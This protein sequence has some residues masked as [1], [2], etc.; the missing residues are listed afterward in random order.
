MQQ[1]FKLQRIIF[2]LATIAIFIVCAGFV[3]NSQSDFKLVDILGKEHPAA[4]QYRKYLEKYN[5]ENKVFILIESKDNSP[6]ELASIDA[7]ITNVLLNT[8]GLEKVRSLSTTEYF[9]PTKDRLLLSPF[10]KNNQIDTKAFEHLTQNDFWKDLFTNS[11]REFL[12]IETHLR[13]KSPSEITI[14]KLLEYKNSFEMQN[15]GLRMHLL[16][17]KLA[18]FYFNEELKNQQTKM[19]P[20][21]IIVIIALLFYFF[22]S[23]KLILIAGFFLAL[24]FACSILIIFSFEKGLNPYTNFSLL[25]IFVIGTADIVHLFQ[26]VINSEKT[27]TPEKVSH[28]LRRITKPCFLTSFTTAIAFLSLLASD[29]SIIQKFGVYSC[30]GVILC[31]ILTIIVLPKF[32]VWF[33]INFKTFQANDLFS[34]NENKYYNFIKKYSTLISLSSLLLIILSITS[35]FYIKFDD[36]LYNKFTPKHPLSLAVQSFQKHLGFT[37]TIDLIIKKGSSDDFKTRTY[38]KMANNFT[39]EILSIPNVTRVQGLSNFLRY[40]RL[41]LGSPMT[42]NK[43][44]ND[45][46]HLKNTFGLFKKSGVLRDHYSSLLNEVKITVYVRSLYSS[47]LAQTIKQINKTMLK[48][49]LNY[50]ISGFAPVRTAMLDVITFGFV[51]SFAGTLLFIFIVMIIVFRSFSWGMITMIPNLM[52]IGVVFITLSISGIQAEDFIILSVCV[53]L[54]L[55][56]DDTLHFFISF[57]R[58]KETEANLEQNL[59]KTFKETHKA[60]I[61]TTLIFVAVTPCYFISSIALFGKMAI[62]ML[63]AMLMALIADF[64]VIPAALIYFNKENKK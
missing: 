39:A 37:G 36:S 6:L 2:S 54:G 61:I 10:I 55:S 63:A 46:I 9:S 40:M 41:E 3:S 20:L 62:V 22:R 52:P 59:K 64:L 12:V 32:L 13:E 4:I 33:D 28:V 29:V 15:K 50:T 8:S 49:G 60:L 44:F 35:A 51:K 21:I 30:I 45:D 23:F 56:V 31:Y 53:L 16:G 47:E 38:E 25:F 5:D 18:S 24:I 1:S 14:S 7:G 17:S 43:S 27:N 57:F 34:I 58:N 26:G 19:S 48:T 42:A 11:E